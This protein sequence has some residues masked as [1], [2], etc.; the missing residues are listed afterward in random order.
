MTPIVQTK[1]SCACSCRHAIFPKFISTSIA[2]K[3][4]ISVKAITTAKL[5]AAALCAAALFG[6]QGGTPSGDSKPEAK[7]DVQVLAEVNGAA[8]TTADFNRELKNLP[9]YLKAMADTP[10]GRKEML[11]TM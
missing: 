3:K 8:I 5:I 10:E 4:E 9:D 7:K 2:E 11:D 1:I 6:C